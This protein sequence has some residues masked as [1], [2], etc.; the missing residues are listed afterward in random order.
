MKIGNINVTF[1]LPRGKK[2]E[3]VNYWRLYKMV[4]IPKVVTTRYAFLDEPD[5]VHVKTSRVYRTEIVDATI[6]NYTIDELRELDLTQN[7]Y[8]YFIAF[9]RKGRK[10]R[11]FAEKIEADRAR[12]EKWLAEHAFNDDH[13]LWLHPWYRGK[14][15]Y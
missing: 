13:I 2:L 1:Q 8:E 9:P 10:N 15:G 3:E 12:R 5:V 14:R 7:K 4:R 11:A 6:S